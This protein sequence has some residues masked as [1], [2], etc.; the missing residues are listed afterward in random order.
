MFGVIAVSLYCR[1]GLQ[2][3]V[4][5][6]LIQV[7]PPLHFRL[8]EFWPGRLWSALHVLLWLLP[9][10][11]FILTVIA[12][13]FLL[14]LAVVIH[15]LADGHEPLLRRARAWR[16]FATFMKSDRSY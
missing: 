12:I 6:Q 1:V 5:P 3:G 14:L 10:I 2:D 13:L 16:V 7:L 8:H 9:R 4:H 15:L 11:L